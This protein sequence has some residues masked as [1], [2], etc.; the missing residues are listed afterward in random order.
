[1]GVS[2]SFG[3]LPQPYGSEALLLKLT[4]FDGKTAG[5]TNPP[6]SR[7]KRTPLVRESPDLPRI[8]SEIVHEGGKEE[9]HE[10]VMKRV[11]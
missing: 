9:V 10:F 3:P 1:M 2:R 6:N 5:F 4:S 11:R 7:P 8:R